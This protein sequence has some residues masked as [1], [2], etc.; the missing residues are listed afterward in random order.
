MVRAPG[1]KRLPGAIFHDRREPAAGGGQDARST[2]DRSLKDAG[3]RNTSMY[4]A[5][6][7]SQWLFKSATHNK[8][9]LALIEKGHTQVPVNG[10]TGLGQG[11]SFN[12]RGT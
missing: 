3:L 5:L 11:E 1:S 8:A 2:P 12:S 9:Q 7:A 6:R 4:F 10:A